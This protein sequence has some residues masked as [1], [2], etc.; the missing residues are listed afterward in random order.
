MAV[1][2]TV[3]ETCLKRTPRVQQERCQHA[4]QGHEW[5]GPQAIGHPNGPW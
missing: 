2:T 4:T 3:A 5:R 1:S